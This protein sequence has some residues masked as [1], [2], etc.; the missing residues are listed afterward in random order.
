MP[1]AA[2]A[3]SW[4]QRR[5]FCLHGMINSPT[6]SEGRPPDGARAPG[7]ERPRP[8]LPRPVATNLLNAIAPTGGGPAFQRRLGPGQGVRTEENERERQN[9]L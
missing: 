8:P 9:T 7:G 5:F 3:P 1:G 6:A 2:S 4:R